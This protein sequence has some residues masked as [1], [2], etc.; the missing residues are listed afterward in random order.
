[1]IH[2]FLKLPTTSS[3]Q[4]LVTTLLII[5]MSLN[6]FSTEDI[7]FNKVVHKKTLKGNKKTQ[8]KSVGG[9]LAP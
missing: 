2:A 9:C 1:M 6:T 3:V 4:A 7:S 5:F 8:Q